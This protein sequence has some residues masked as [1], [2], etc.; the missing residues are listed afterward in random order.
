MNRKNRVNYW[1]VQKW[2]LAKIER[3]FPLIFKQRYLEVYRQL[4]VKRAS[5]N[6]NGISKVFDIHRLQYFTFLRKS[7]KQNVKKW[8]CWSNLISRSVFCH[9][10]L[11]PG[12]RLV[13]QAFFLYFAYLRYFLPKMVFF[14]NLHMYIYSV[15]INKFF[16]NVVYLILINEKSW[17]SIKLN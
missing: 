8:V 12:I 11:K 2:R 17:K 10:Y 13:N 15:S 6:W 4:S 1:L 7:F 9:S 3:W 14:L 16:S 5:L